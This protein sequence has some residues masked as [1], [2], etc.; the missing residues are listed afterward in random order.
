VDITGEYR[1]A[2]PRQTVWAALND[3]QVLKACIPGCQSLVQRSEDEIEAEVQAQLG[4]VRST[5]TTRITIS[6]RVPPTSYTLTGEGKSGAAGFGKG[7]AHVNLADDGPGTRLAYQ[8]ELQLGGR[9][10]QIGSRLVSGATAKLAQDFFTTFARELDKNA[11]QVA[12]PAVL[13]PPA[14]QNSRRHWWL[15]A[16]LALAM[17]VLFIWWRRAH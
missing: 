11:V 12:A 17:L 9:L 7:I 14:V 13:A 4:P 10:A 15:F 5:F 2:A 1:I 16:A 8:A 3:P 6:D